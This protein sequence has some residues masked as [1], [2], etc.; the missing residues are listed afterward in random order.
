[1]RLKK[2]VYNM[3]FIFFQQVVTAIYGL[4]IPALLIKT[5]GSSTNGIIASITQFLSYIVLLEAGVGSVIGSALYK[6]L[7]TGDMK[8]ISGI[9]KATE[10]F[11]HKLAKIFLVY[12]CVV[13]V[14][15]PYFVRNQFG[16]LFT[17]SLVFIISVSTLAQYYFGITYQLL[18]Q[19]DQKRWIVALLQ[20]G[21][22]VAALFITLGCVKLNLS[23]HLLKVL[24]AGV[25]VVRPLALRWYVKKNYRLDDKVE[26]DNEALSQRWDGLA[27]HIAYIIHYNTDI[28]VLTFFASMLEVSVYSVY[29]NIVSNIYKII[30]SVTLGLQASV[31]NIIAKKEKELLERTLN[32]Y[33]TLNFML[34][35]IFYSCV[36][37]LIFPFVK[38]YTSGVQ[39]VNYIRMNFAVFLVLS[40]A[41][42]GLRSP[43]D[44][45]IFASGHFKQTRTGAYI[46]AGLNI[47][48]SLL[49]VRKWGITGVAVGTLAAMLF[50]AVHYAFY[51]QNN[52]IYRPVNIFLR[53][54]AVNFWTGFTVVFVFWKFTF[55]IHSYQQW[56]AHAI[57]VFLSVTLINILINLVFQKKE[58]LGIIHHFYKRADRGV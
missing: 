37:I 9:V 5:Y 19:A 22:T 23:I 40:E 41:A 32:E 52:I 35:N 7:A 6:P 55:E 53:K 8:R 57:V 27:H 29:Y 56:F 39:D 47:G 42:Y 48:I 36:L 58:I 28:T 43:Y 15:Y 16:W 24:V 54:L 10:I 12:L 33:E 2:S 14:V 13:A 45:I 20:T 1:M 25:Y 44:M 46:E 26:A 4:V 3:T 30:S 49:L 21:S 50:R 34:I 31:G 18:L 51:L 38:L 11:F 17:F